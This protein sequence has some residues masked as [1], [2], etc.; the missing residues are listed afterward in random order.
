MINL[1]E[2]GCHKFPGPLGR[3]VGAAARNAGHD[4]QPVLL[5]Y[6]RVGAADVAHVFLVEEDVD[7]SA[8]LAPLVVEMLA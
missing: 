3:P 7:E 2:R 4:H 5:T 8:Q 1:L 6:R